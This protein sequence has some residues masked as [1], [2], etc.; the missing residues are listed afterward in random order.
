MQNI[1][2]KSLTREIS[3]AV[4]GFDSFFFFVCHSVWFC[5]CVCVCVS[6]F[7]K[8]MNLECP[9]IGRDRDSGKCVG[10]TTTIIKR[11]VVESKKK[12][13]SIRGKAKRKALGTR[14]PAEGKSTAVRHLGFSVFGERKVYLKYVYILV[15][16][17]PAR[18]GHWLR[19][20]PGMNLVHIPVGGKKNLS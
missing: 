13:V 8:K 19:L 9:R 11:S 6:G 3:W 16:A 5:V 15:T 20:F 10:R 4:L 14:G 2:S 18:R 12:N 7:G 1:K 17:P